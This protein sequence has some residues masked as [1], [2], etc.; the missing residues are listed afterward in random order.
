MRSS[1]PTDISSRSTVDLDE[2]EVPDWER[3]EI[4]RRTQ[5]RFRKWVT[6]NALP[7]LTALASGIV[8]LLTTMGLR[9]EGAPQELARYKV[10]AAIDHTALVDRVGKTEGAISQLVDDDRDLKA[11]VK[12]QR[13]LLCYII[14]KQDSSAVRVIQSCAGVKAP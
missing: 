4:E 6:A 13:Y 14:G 9:M 8:L 11:A 3:R 7:L 10:Q 5:D 12:E 1:R 2:R